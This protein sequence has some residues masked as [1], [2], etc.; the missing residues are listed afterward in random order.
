MNILNYETDAEDFIPGSERVIAIEM[1]GRFSEPGSETEN[2]QLS[3][4][5]GIQV[6]GGCLCGLSD[7]PPMPQTAPKF[8]AMSGLIRICLLR[9]PVSQLGQTFAIMTDSW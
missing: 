2:N 9:N 3:Y 8:D 5:R 7:T 4:N 1:T 6:V